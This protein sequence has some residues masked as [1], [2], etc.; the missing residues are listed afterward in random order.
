MKNL[1]EGDLRAL[2]NFCRKLFVYQYQTWKSEPNLYHLILYLIFIA[3]EMPY[4][5]EALLECVG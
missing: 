3:T 4:T 2:W 1:K 5:N